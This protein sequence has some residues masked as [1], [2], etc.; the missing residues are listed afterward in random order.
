MPLTTGDHVSG[1]TDL[2]A[3]DGGAVAVVDGEADLQSSVERLHEETDVTGDAHC[4]E[5]TADTNAIA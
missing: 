2:R 5:L 4:M 1:E 3:A